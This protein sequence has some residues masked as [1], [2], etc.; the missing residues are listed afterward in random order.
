MDSRRYRHYRRARAVLAALDPDELCEP[1]REILEDLAEHMLLSAE[2]RPAAVREARQ[3]AS[4]TVR[5]LAAAGMVPPAVA[6]QLVSLVL[7]AGP[8]LQAEEAAA[9]G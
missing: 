8:S 1:A 9:H 3:E 2:V 7:G 6:N 5:E 4:S